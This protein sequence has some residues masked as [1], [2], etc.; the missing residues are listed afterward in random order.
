MVKDHLYSKGGNELPSHHRLPFP[1]SST[2]CF[3]CVVP[4][5]GQYTP[6]PVLQQLWGIGLILDWQYIRW[7]LHLEFLIHLWAPRTHL[8]SS[9]TFGLLAHIWAPHTPLGFSYTFM[10][11]VHFWAPRTPLGSSYTFGLLIHF[12]APHTPLGSSYTFGLL[13]HLWAPHTPLG[14]SYT[15]GLLIHFWAPHTPLGSSCTFT[16][17]CTLKRLNLNTW[18]V[19]LTTHYDT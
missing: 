6:C 14:S 13:I 12:W 2:V 1:M 3:I 10:I 17:E 5:T 18:E 19:N 16:N 15:F 7:Q 9:Y 4:R 11:I 8:G